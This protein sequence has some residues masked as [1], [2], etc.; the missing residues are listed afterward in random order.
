MQLTGESFVEHLTS[1][2]QEMLP[3]GADELIMLVPGGTTTCLG[4]TCT[5]CCCSAAAGIE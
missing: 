2:N 5:S 3:T 4:C 1:G